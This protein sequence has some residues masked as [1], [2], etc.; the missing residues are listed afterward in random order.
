M[1]GSEVYKLRTTECESLAK[2]IGIQLKYKNRTP[3]L[4]Q[5][6]IILARYLKHDSEL[7]KYVKEEIDSATCEGRNKENPDIVWDNNI[8]NVIL[9]AR[10]I[11]LE[12]S[13]TV[14]QPENF[15]SLID[16]IIE[17]D[18][19]DYRRAVKEEGIEEEAD[20]HDTANTSAETVINNPTYTRDEQLAALLNTHSIAVQT[21]EPAQ[22]RIM[23][24]EQLLRLL[25]SLKESKEKPIKL[26]NF[27]GKNEEDITEHISNFEKIAAM[28]GWHENEKSKKYLKTLANEAQNYAM[29]KIMRTEGI[30]PWQEMKDGMFRRYRKG[31]DQWELLISQTKQAET[32]DPEDYIIKIDALCEKANPNMTGQSRVNKVIQ[33]LLPSIRKEVITRNNETIDE[34]AK[35]I[36]TI[37]TNKALY[38]DETNELLHKLIDT[39]EK[40]DEQKEVTNSIPNQPTTYANATKGFN[41]GNNGGFRGGFRGGRGRGRNFRSNNGFRTNLSCHFCGIP[42]HLIKDCRKKQ[43]EVSNGACN[44]CGKMGHYANNCWHNPKS[45]SYKGKNEKG[46]NQ[47]VT[48]SIPNTDEQQKN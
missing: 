38:K 3:T 28:E 34:L 1:P 17:E 46:N 48:N 24:D 2:A 35:S 16:K 31:E 27:N 11:Q 47:Q 22:P 23:N 44:T 36:R 43:R 15:D 33:G 40:K 18:F 5:K 4:A 13:E 14:E 37:K 25:N 19:D 9:A 45:Q 26:Q 20:Y 21:R 42:G 12:Y 8:I 6:R 29:K 39:I 32:E 30:T 10:R 41:R 7:S